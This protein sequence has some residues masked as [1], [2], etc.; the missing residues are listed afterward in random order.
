VF[1]QDYFGITKA[2]LAPFYYDKGNLPAPDRPR[3]RCL[4][5]CSCNTTETAS[6]TS[7]NCKSDEYHAI[8]GKYGSVSNILELKFEVFWTK[9][10]KI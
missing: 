9:G 5:Q 4:A 6:F 1:E 2:P 3:D 7:A 10:Y 8:C